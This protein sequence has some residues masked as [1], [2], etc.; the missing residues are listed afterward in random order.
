MIIKETSYPTH[1]VAFFCIHKVKVRAAYL[2]SVITIMSSEILA[3][4]F[5]Y[6]DNTKIKVT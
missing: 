2:S 4:V 3:N 1:P 6:C 5:D